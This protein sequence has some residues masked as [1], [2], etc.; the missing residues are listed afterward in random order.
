M[1]PERGGKTLFRSTRPAEEKKALLI[2]TYSRHPPE[3]PCAVKWEINASPMKPNNGAKVQSQFVAMDPLRKKMLSDP[4]WT[5]IPFI[6]DIHIT[7]LACRCGR[8][9]WS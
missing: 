2:E 4:D 9:P 6:S 8:L 5:T 7:Y 1:A 3:V